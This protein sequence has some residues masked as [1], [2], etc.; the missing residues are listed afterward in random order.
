MATGNKYT[1]AELMKLDLFTRAEIIGK[2]SDSERS[3][4]LKTVTSADIPQGRSTLR[5]AMDRTPEHENT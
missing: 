5:E 3:E 2:M 1:F 4:V